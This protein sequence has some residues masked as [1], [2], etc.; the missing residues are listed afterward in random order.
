MT[1]QDEMNKLNLSQQ[2]A[3]RAVLRGRGRPVVFH[4]NERVSK[5]TAEFK[6]DSG[7]HVAHHVMLGKRGR[8]VF[9]EV[10]KIN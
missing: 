10:Q 5:V 7:L 3:L 4:V 6:Y 2:R 1:A 9:H 8:I